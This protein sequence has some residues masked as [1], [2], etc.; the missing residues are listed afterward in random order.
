MGFQGYTL[1]ALGFAGLVI[2]I[3]IISRRAGKS[4]AKKEMLEKENKDHEKDAKINAQPV[5]SG[6]DLTSAFRKWVRKKRK[7]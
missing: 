5:K 3:A 1:I 6:D 4:E 7:D 2:T